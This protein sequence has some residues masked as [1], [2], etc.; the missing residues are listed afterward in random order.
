MKAVRTDVLKKHFDNALIS[1]WTK[2][3]ILTVIET[4]SE[5]FPEPESEEIP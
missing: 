3:E 5:D 2:A 1:L 4:L